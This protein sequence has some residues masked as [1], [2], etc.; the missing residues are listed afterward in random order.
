M[1][2]SSLPP[3]APLAHPA[4][5]QGAT[6]D[7]GLDALRRARLVGVVSVAGIALV[8]TS[9]AFY[10]LMAGRLVPVVATGVVV[11]GALGTAALLRRTTRL[12]SALMLGTIA[13]ACPL[14]AAQTGGIDAPMLVAVPMIPILVASFAGT[15]GALAVGAALA[16][17]GVTLWLADRAGS[18]APS[19]LTSDANDAMRVV[20]ALG[21]LVVTTG[22]GVAAERERERLEAAL[23]ARSRLLYEASVH[24]GL[25]RV[26]NRRYLTERMDQEL[27]YARRHGTAL[28]VVMVDVDHFKRINDDLGHAGGDA[29]LV[30]VAARL[31]AAVRREDVVARYG[32]EEFAILL[33]GLELDG[34]CRVAER[35]RASIAEPAFTVGGGPL[36][37]T[38]SAGCASLACASAATP[39]GLLAAADARL[40]LAK[41]AGRNR[42]VWLD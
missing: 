25:T 23:A 34:A 16:V 30:E 35:V 37:I 11:V 3:T 41:R 12:A 14:M 28:A 38:V 10:T 5:V 40:Y 27:A 31:A 6:A 8:V 21:S 24:D 29:V 20:I 42:V 18:I 15:R 26:Y 32:G 19:P 13:I 7:T 22:M 1:Q 39:D 9:I 17:G 4:I 2:V 36:R 33:R